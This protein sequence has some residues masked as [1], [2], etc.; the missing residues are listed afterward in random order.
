MEA[1]SYTHLNLEEAE[2]IMGNSFVLLVSF[3]LCLTA[4]GLIFKRPLLYLLGASDMTI[5]YADSYLTIY[6]LGSTFVM[7][8]LGMNSF[9]NSQGFGKIGMMTVLLGAVANLILDPVFIFVFHMGVQG[10]ALA[11][12]IS[13]GLSALWIIR[14]LTGKK[15]ILRLKKSSFV[16]EAE[17]VKSIMFL[18]LSGFTMS[19]TNS[20]VP[21]S[22]THLGKQNERQRRAENSRGND[23]IL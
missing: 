16:L 23:R 9:I 7:I 15:T 21:V 19:I 17:R 13:Q 1:V 3:G 2:K 4:A 10:A 20:L 14:F 22:Y 11:T 12:I 6:L 18:G 5:E 8:G